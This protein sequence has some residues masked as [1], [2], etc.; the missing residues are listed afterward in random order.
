MIDIQSIIIYISLAI[1]T[2]FLGKIAEKRDDN[3][4]VC[5]IVLLL[6]LVAGLRAVSVG[7]DTKTYNTV[8]NIV[9][10]GTVKAMYGIEESF[11]Y[12]CSILLHI[13]DNNHFVFFV[14]AL[15]SNGLIVFRIWEE[16]ENVAFRWAVLTYYVMFFAFSL[17]GLRQFI[18]VGFVIYATRFVKRGEYIR[19]A[20]LIAFAAAFHTSAL[21]G[22]AYLSLEMLSLR[23]YTSK[24]KFKISI[25]FVLTVVAFL[26]LS[27][28][29]L[30]R[31]ANYFEWKVTSVGVMLLAKTLLLVASI[32][33]IGQAGEQKNGDGYTATS[34][35][36]YY[37]V[38]LLLTSLNY[39]FLYM[40]RIGLYFYI[41]EAFYIGY[42]FKIK[43]Y[44]VEIIF[45]KAGYILILMYYLWS[46]ITHGGQGELPYRFFYQV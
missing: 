46:S 41:F 29:I 9:S 17:N 10:A 11:I 39:F 38:G 31:Y 32:F 3:T 19:F 43:N 22:I 1:C 44:T 13:W 42:V 7:I 23:Y 18:A 2:F 16:R 20:L 12:I 6:S 35:R 40:G 14:F 30:E 4:A 45:L 33:I 34:Y 37:F 36:W 26:A 5:L 27:P 25:I 15:I 28:E 21:I 8:F 24:K